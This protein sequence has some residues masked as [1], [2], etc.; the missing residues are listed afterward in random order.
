MLPSPLRDSLLGAWIMSF[1]R[2]TNEVD[3]SHE[4]ELHGPCTNS[5]TMIPIQEDSRALT[6]HCARVF[7]REGRSGLAN[8]MQSATASRERVSTQ[9]FIRSVSNQWKVLGVNM[10]TR[11]SG[12]FRGLLIVVVAVAGRAF[13]QGDAASLTIRFAA[14]TSQFHIGEVIPIELSFTASLGDT[15]DLDTR[16]YDRS[17]RLNTEQFH[18]TPPGRDPLVNY[19]ANGAFL[20]GGLGGSRVLSSEPQVM[21]EDLNEWVALDDP[22]HYTLDVTTGRV[23][24]RGP[25]KNESLQLR[26]NSLEFDVIAADPVWQEQTLAAAVSVLNSVASTDEEKREAIRTLRFLDSPQSVQEL[27][28]QMGNLPDGR[29]F[30][31]IGGLAGSR[32]QSQVVQE[33]E[34][35][36][37]APDTAITGEYLYTLAKLKLQLDHPL[38]PPYPEH[39]AQQQKIWQERL[40]VQEKELTE[41]QDALF[42]KAAAIVSTKRGHARAETVHAL[43][44]RPARGSQDI[45]PLTALPDAE[46][47][48]AFL[49]LSPD[50]QWSL[51]STFWERLRL[52][53]MVTALETIIAEPEIKHQMLRD[54][55]LQRLYELDPA[56]A[57]PYILDEIKRPHVDDGMFTVRAKTLGVLPQETLPEFD[58]LL[59]ER[60]E[61]KDAQTMPLDA[62]LVGRYSTK[63]ILPTVKSIY[64][65]AA[66]GWDCV[67]E[68]GFVLYFLRTEP[69]YG[70]QRLSAAPSFCMTGSIPVVIKMKRWG[71][72]ETSVI[73]QLNNPDLNR[74][75]QAAETLSK[76]GSAKAETA[77]WERMR[78]FHQQWASRANDLSYRQSTPR[79]ASDAISFQYGLVES[80]ARAQAWLLSDEQVADLEQLTLG[81]ERDNLKQYHWSSPVA[82]SLQL[83]FDGQLRADINHQYFPGDVTSLRAKLA[84]YPSGTKFRLTTF[85]EPSHLAP[86][87]EDV[88][89]AAVEYGLTIEVVR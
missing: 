44:S 65:A 61:R 72:I 55:A 17:G 23:S 37:N 63:A 26:S 9:I 53:A 84:Q 29:R 46:V 56:E 81:S 68:D 2:G 45:T 32:H 78:R 15:Y 3:S 18:V 13:P 87:L 21:R 24:R 83:L 75:R 27:V 89:E 59:A 64:E 52:P 6:Y 76:Y 7:L 28:R 5:D 25:T 88:N 35:Q 8:H 1:R 71:E 33:L 85:G 70:V 38:L 48:S 49:A 82:L 14:G 16:N 11:P 67:T 43:L 57:T 19:Y 30:D 34:R 36:M 50:Q 66:G 41:V 22:G 77:M 86:V 74:A 51:L 4:Y 79:D 20:G 10:G 40:Q 62:Q 39:D 42:R 73:A 54:A 47:A 69:K 80:L 31:C 58:Q 12:F 60:L